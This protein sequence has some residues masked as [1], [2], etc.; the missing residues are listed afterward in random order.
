MTQTAYNDIMSIPEDTWTL[1]SEVNCTFF[2]N[3][4]MI[5]LIGMQDAAPTTEQ[6]VAYEQGQGEEAATD[7]LAR[8]SGAGTANRLYAR[9]IGGRRANIFLS[10][11]SVA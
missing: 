6:G 1:I 10:R 9:A 7:V 5:E 8:Y 3:G 11:A 2:V 4:G